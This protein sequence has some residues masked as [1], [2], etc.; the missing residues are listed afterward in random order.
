MDAHT[1]YL[2][3]YLILLGSDILMCARNNI[4]I[5]EH[6]IRGLCV[7]MSMRYSFAYMVQRTI[8]V[9]NYK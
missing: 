4:E 2:I 7:K 6:T 5:A 8:C 1:N 9:S 3:A